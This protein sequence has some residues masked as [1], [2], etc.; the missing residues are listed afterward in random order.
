MLEEQPEVDDV[1]DLLTMQTG[2]DRVLVCARV[3]FVDDYS[4]ADLEKAC[5]RIDSDM[6]EQFTDLDEIFIQ[7]VPRS[8]PGLRQRVRAR[9]GRA[10]AEPR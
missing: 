9:Y 5:L 6:R 3:D 4:A 8:D 7:P 2:T 1:V 10:L